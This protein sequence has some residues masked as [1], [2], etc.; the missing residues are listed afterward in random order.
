MTGE[1]IPINPAAPERMPRVT[2][3]LAAQ[4]A[5]LSLRALGTVTAGFRAALLEAAA[6]GDHHAA[7][8]ALREWE[9]SLPR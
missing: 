3:I 6:R 1:I 9:W 8:E 4:Q 2:A 7:R 5:A